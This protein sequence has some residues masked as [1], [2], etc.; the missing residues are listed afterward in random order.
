MV[1]IDL[2]DL[3][4]YK[5]KTVPC[6]CENKN[7]GKIFYKKS[8]QTKYDAK[9]NVIS[10][11]YCSRLCKGLAENKKLSVNCLNCDVTF[12]KR[13][14]DCKKT[15]NHF[16]GRSCAATYNN[17]HKTTGTR[18]SKLEVWIE[19]QLTEKYH[20]LEIHFNKKDAI[21][22]ELDIYVPSLKLAFELNGIFHYEPIFGED[23][24]DSILNNDQRKFQACLERK[25]ELCI[26]DTTS[27]KSFKPKNSQ[28]YLDIITSLIE[29]KLNN[30]G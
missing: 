15:P 4:K 16:C 8:D 20:V 10:G 17:K 5:G 6:Q 23:K 18:R 11:K 29:L 1:L 24:L 19:A 3:S 26:I 21:N 22:S 27:Q 9:V 25:I 30:Q 7:C 12:I 14:C 13:F 28:K 2:S